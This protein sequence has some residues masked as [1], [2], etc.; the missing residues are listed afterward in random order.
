MT[1]QQI[2]QELGVRGWRVAEQVRPDGILFR[3]SPRGATPTADN[4][5]DTPDLAEA[6]AFAEASNKTFKQAQTI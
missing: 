4:R 1:T 5:I 3:V 6:L 2:T